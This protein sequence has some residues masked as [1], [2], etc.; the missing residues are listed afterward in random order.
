MIHALDTLLGW[1]GIKVVI[2][3]GKSFKVVRTPPESNSGKTKR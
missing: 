3:D 2:V 1:Q